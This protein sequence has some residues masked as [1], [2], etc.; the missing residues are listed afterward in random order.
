MRE[1]QSGLE[2]KSSQMADELDVGRSRLTIIHTYM[3][4]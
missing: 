1:I 3:R 4:V 2:M